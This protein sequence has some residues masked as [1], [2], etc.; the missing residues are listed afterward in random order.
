VNVAVTDLSASS[1]TAHVP[2]PVHAPDHPVNADPAD[3]VAVSVTPVP[4]L[5][6][7]EPAPLI[8]D[9]ELATVPLPVPAAFTVS[10]CCTGSSWKF[11]VLAP[12]D[13]SVSATE[14]DA[15]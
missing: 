15:V 14:F 3:G 1:V 2:V 5:N 13:V 6:A 7:L 4:A 12:P 9:G 8:P 10:V 11:C